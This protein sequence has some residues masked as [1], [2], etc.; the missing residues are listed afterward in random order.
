MNV[1]ESSDEKIKATDY[2]SLKNKIKNHAQYWNGIWN[3]YLNIG[4]NWTPSKVAGNK[5]QKIPMNQTIP[6][7]IG[8]ETIRHKKSLP[9]KETQ[10]LYNNIDKTMSNKLNGLTGYNN[11]F[12]D[13]V[14]DTYD[15]KPYDK[16]K[17]EPTSNEKNYAHEL[18]TEN[19]IRDKIRELNTR[20]VPSG[21][22]NVF[23]FSDY[24]QN[25]TYEKTELK[26]Y[27]VNYVSYGKN[28]EVKDSE[29]YWTNIEQ[30]FNPTTEVILYKD[31]DLNEKD[32]EVVVHEF[33]HGN[34][35]VN[36]R[37]EWTG[38]RYYE[39][40]PASIIT[41]NYEEVNGQWV[42]LI[43]NKDYANQTNMTSNNSQGVIVSCNA[44]NEIY[45]LFRDD[46]KWIDFTRKPSS[47]NPI[48]I[49]FSINKPF[50]LTRY[51][52][53]AD[54]QVNDWEPPC[55]WKLQ[56]SNDNSNWKTLET[57]TYNVEA[58][59]W[60][61]QGLRRSF[62]V[63]SNTSAYLYYRLNITESRKTKGKTMEL[64][65]MRF[66]GKIYNDIKTTQPENIGMLPTK[67]DAKDIPNETT[68]DF[69][70]YDDYDQKC[71][72]VYMDKTK[73]WYKLKNEEYIKKHEYDQLNKILDSIG[74]CLKKKDGWFSNGVCNFSCQ[75]KCQ[76]SCQ[77]SCQ[78]CNTK[79]CHDQKCGT[80]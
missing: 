26:S 41:G 32:K 6:E 28:L 38:D 43:F 18:Y 53:R 52:L 58:P 72:Y 71:V 23:K 47:D 25:T 5:G 78:L 40:K 44:Q 31:K 68:K 55:A 14:V 59:K 12:V 77:V 35:Y 73:Q 80:H 70:K 66:F 30:S 39:T 51:E 56:A 60:N 27:K 36:K 21:I 1:K 17:D 79:Q 69:P 63:S 65:G 57:Y 37:V 20:L 29:E 8:D 54:N 22:N 16:K 74:N 50:I 48:Y 24:A 45:K 15:I 62:D 13:D 46:A 11:Y 64:A 4:P 61:K 42:K 2:Q 33:K 7:R 76:N 9:Y 67:E 34:N 19:Q 49:N 10:S 75:V 3:A